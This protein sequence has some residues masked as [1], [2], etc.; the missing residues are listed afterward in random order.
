MFRRRDEYAEFLRLHAAGLRGR[1][2]HIVRPR[3][4]DLGRQLA[5]LG[6]WLVRKLPRSRI[7]FPVGL[8]FFLAGPGLVLG[9]KLAN[10]L[11]GDALATTEFPLGDLRDVAVDPAGRIYVADEFHSRVQRYAPDG[12]FQLGWPVPTAGVFA[13][14]T[15]ADGRV[16][17]ATARANKLLT[18]DA[19]GRLLDGRYGLKEDRYP[20]FV[21][22]AET[23]G[24]YAVRRGLRPRVVD[25]RTGRTV[26][27]TPG[28]LWL[29]TG[30]FPAMLYSAIGVA[31]LL[32]GD[33][34]RRYEPQPGGRAGD[35]SEAPAVAGG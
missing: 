11:G 4:A 24:P 33:W 26:I 10:K 2:G 34:R 35:R 14:R 31:I 16:L 28:P 6:R 18:Y 32:L 23:T 15:T 17:V 3:A 7:L 30:P 8:T 13:L 25:T 9:W 5:G 19:D 20:E 27:P 12:E 29:V 21:S 1:L 22:E